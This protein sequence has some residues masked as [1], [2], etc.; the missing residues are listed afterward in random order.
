MLG[1]FRQS[2][3]RVS[4]SLHS[5]LCTSAQGESASLGPCLGDGSVALWAVRGVCALVLFTICLR[6]LELS[7][8]RW[9]LPLKY[10][11]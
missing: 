2:L 11:T 5:S 8:A 1:N 6:L 7:P 9:T 4:V 3:Q 10:Q